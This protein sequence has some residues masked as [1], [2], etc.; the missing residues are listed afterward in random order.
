M[1]AVDEVPASY[2]AVDRYNGA[3]LLHDSR[4]AIVPMAIQPRDFAIV[5][6]VWRYKFLTAPMVRELHWSGGSMWPA[7]R[8]LQ[9]SSTPGSSSASAR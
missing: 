4:A 5:L 3:V 7:Q 2:A 8:R 6:D 1:S 9:K